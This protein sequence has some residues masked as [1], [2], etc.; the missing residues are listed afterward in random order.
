[1]NQLQIVEQKIR[2]ELSALQTEVEA[3][4]LQAEE[5]RLDGQDKMKAYI[6]TL[7]E[8]RAEVVDRLDDLSDSGGKALDE[9]KHGLKDAQQ[10]L[11]IAK[12]AAKARF[13]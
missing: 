3:L 4:K 9:I 12:K 13:H 6:E 11:A 5:A 7:D 2:V 1:M 10:R 8:K